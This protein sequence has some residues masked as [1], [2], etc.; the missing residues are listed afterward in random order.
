M[1]LIEVA[2]HLIEH[3]PIHLRVLEDYFDEFYLH[4]SNFRSSWYRA[5]K[6]GWPEGLEVVTVWFDGTGP[7][8]VI[9]DYDESFIKE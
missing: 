9:Y 3:E 8:P 5:E 6:E 2:S 7:V 4:S 1:A